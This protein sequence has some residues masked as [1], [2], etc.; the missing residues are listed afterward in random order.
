MK[1]ATIAIALLLIGCAQYRWTHP[2]FT[3]ANWRR[4]T[5]ECE[6]DMRQSA[7]FGGG[8]VGQINATDFQE[9]CLQA[10]GY[11]KVKVESLAGTITP[12]EK[13]TTEAADKLCSQVVCESSFTPHQCSDPD[14]IKDV[15]VELCRRYGKSAS[16]EKSA[17][18]P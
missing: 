2:S 11:T 4:D 16:A 6:R 8:I 5:Y 18:A 7:Y 1:I 10:R 3:E 13:K 17:A 14:R 9:R 12:L 15:D